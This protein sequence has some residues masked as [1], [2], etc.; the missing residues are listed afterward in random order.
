MWVLGTPDLSRLPT[1]QGLGRSPVFHAHA[2]VPNNQPTPAVTAIASAPQN[3]TRIAPMVTPAP[4]TR[5]AN[6]PRSAR[7]T[8][9]VPDTRGI[10]VASG[11]MAVTKIGMAAPAAKLPA[12]AN[13]AWIGRAARASDMPSSSRACVPNASLLHQLLGNLFCKQRIETASNVDRRQFLV[14]AQVVRREFGALQREVGLFGA[15]WEW[16]D[17]YSPAAIDIAPATGRRP[18]PPKCCRGSHGQ[19]RHRAPDSM[20]KGCR[21]SRPVPPHVTSRSARSGVV[22][23]CLQAFWGLRDLGTACIVRVYLTAEGQ[24]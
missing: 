23:Y 13:A 16:T 8:R 1:Y 20:S 12:D 7:N 3:V 5:A 17:T 15:A 4:P 6:P 24:P 19:L 2:T 9:E 14:F 10:R 18:P 11:V 21:R 22:P